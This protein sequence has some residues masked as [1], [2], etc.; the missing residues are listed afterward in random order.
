MHPL[1]SPSPMKSATHSALSP[2]PE[3]RQSWAAGSTTPAHCTQWK[4]L[5]PLSPLLSSLPSRQSGQPSFT[6]E[7]LTQ[8]PSQLK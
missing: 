8:R 6:Q 4:I 3:E 5:P 1:H 7:R 2:L